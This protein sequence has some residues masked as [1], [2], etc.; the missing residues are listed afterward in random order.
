M[1]HSIN[2]LFCLHSCT[3]NIV[4]LANTGLESLEAV[5]PIILLALLLISQS[6][7]KTAF[8]FSSQ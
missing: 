6:R 8:K 2:Q 3:N 1:P 5:M 4:F 7:L